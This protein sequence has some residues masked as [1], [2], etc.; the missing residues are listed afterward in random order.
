MSNWDDRYRCP[1]CRPPTDVSRCENCRDADG[2]RVWHSER[3]E[4]VEQ[5]GPGTVC[6]RIRCECG[7]GWPVFVATEPAIARAIIEARSRT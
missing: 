5:V 2:K 4:D 3:I 1:T 7:Q 6:Y